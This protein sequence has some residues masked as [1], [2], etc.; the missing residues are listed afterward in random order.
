MLAKEWLAGGRAGWLAPTRPGIYGAALER[1]SLTETYRPAYLLG[2][3]PPEESEQPLSQPP[4]G[5]PGRS[6]AF[7]SL[8]STANNRLARKERARPTWR[9]G[10]NSARWLRRTALPRCLSLSSWEDSW[11][12]SGVALCAWHDPCPLPAANPAM[13]QTQNSR[14]WHGG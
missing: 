9:P 11:L 2:V 10:N 6:T 3:G 7:E 13:H 1:E 5:G 8:L 14:P 4:A 12:P